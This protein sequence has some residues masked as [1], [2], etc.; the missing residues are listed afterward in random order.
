[1]ETNTNT[2][3]NF[4]NKI[5]LFNAM[6]MLP[7]LATPGVPFVASEGTSVRA[8]FVARLEDFKA[9]LAEELD[10]VDEIINKIK[11]GDHP[12]EVLVGLADWLGDIQVYCASEMRKFGLDNSMVLDIIMASNMSKLGADGRPIYDDRGKV[13]KGP[14]YWRPELLIRQY[15]EAEA[16]QASRQETPESPV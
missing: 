13:M 3:T 12:V 9:I 10:E 2:N 1:M 15:I 8:Q 7:T 6:Y 16:R 11:A 5:K 14:N 4:D